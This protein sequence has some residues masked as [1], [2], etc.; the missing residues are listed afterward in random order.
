MEGY[1]KRLCC[2]GIFALLRKRSLTIRLKGRVLG[3]MAGDREVLCTKNVLLLPQVVK[4]PFSPVPYGQPG[5]IYFSSEIKISSS[6]C[7]EDRTKLAADYY[8]RTKQ[9]I[10]FSRLRAIIS[11]GHKLLCELPLSTRSPSVLNP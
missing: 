3:I 6:S 5:V 8:S 9:T 4:F 11:P 7:W 10:Y 1:D 2:L